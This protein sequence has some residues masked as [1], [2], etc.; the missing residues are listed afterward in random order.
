MVSTY[1]VDGKCPACSASLFPQDEIYMPNLE[2]AYRLAEIRVMKKLAKENGFDDD[3][4][5]S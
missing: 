3:D 5:D 1:V 4:D 2:D